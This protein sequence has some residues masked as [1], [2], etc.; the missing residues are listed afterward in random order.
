MLCYLEMKRD[1]K[2]AKNRESFSARRMSKR[3]LLMLGGTGMTRGQA[4]NI[5]I[6]IISSFLFTECVY[7][8]T[9]LFRKYRTIQLAAWSVVTG[10]LILSVV[11]QIKGNIP[12][13]NAA[14]ATFVL[15]IL[16]FPREKASSG[17]EKE[18]ETKPVAFVKT[19]PIAVSPPVDDHEKSSEFCKYCGEVLYTPN[20]KFCSNCGKKQG[21]QAESIRP[22]YC[23]KCGAAV[24]SN[25]IWCNQCGERVR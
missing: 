6:D 20:A 15:S 13:G 8:L 23:K 21:E 5:I 12:W 7:L 17:E 4:L 9:K 14:L 10:L 25:F 22:K 2:R 24:D 1:G 16:N 18:A 19:A 11:G 3:I